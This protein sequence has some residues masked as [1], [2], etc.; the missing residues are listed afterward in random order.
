MESGLHLRRDDHEI[1]QPSREKV[2]HI[3]D[4]ISIW[5]TSWSNINWL[6][7]FFLILTTM[8]RFLYSMQ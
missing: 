2:A 5:L 3:L 4:D 7:Q 1:I 6:G 8:L